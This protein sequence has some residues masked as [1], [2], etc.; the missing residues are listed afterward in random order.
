MKKMK[1]LPLIMTILLL[2]C[3][4]NA[5]PI[6]PVVKPPV[7]IPTTRVYTI[8]PNPIDPAADVNAK[9]LYTYI[10]SQF[11]KK[12]ISGQTAGQVDFDYIKKVTGMTPLIRDFDM[13]HYSP[14]YSYLWD[15]NAIDPKTGNKGYFSFGPDTGE[16]GVE[17]AISWYNNHDKKPIID[18]QWHWHSPS[19]GIVG[20]NTFYTQYTTFDVT[21]A[22]VSGTQ[23][24]TDAIRDID[25]IAV[26]LKKLSD[27]GVP[28]LWRP[29][30]EIGGTWFWWSAKGPVAAKALWNMIY[31]RLTNFH[32]LHNLIWI[33]N[34][35]DVAWYPGNDK[36]DLASIDSY[37]GNNNYSID[38]SEF[39]KIYS[40]TGGTKILAMSENGP[41]PD[42]NSSLSSD[43]T[44]SFFMSWN[45]VWVGNNDQHLK[46]VY[47]NPNV[48][49]LENYK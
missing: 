45:D 34:G 36:A 26:Q 2:S 27:A 46:D 43:A 12:I 22:V 44:W 8:S 37:P 18:F 7:I 38:K 3:N 5:D 17:T 14:M 19:G 24:N 23:E 20:T 33:W 31:D 13:Q 25:A 42:I 30:H 35:N 39:D 48:I 47:S 6:T 9:R 29:L 10:L 28:I 1:F 41:I 40:I 32:H 11:G 4:K 15:N 49:T 21:K 16:M